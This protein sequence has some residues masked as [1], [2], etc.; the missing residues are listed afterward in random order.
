VVGTAQFD[1]S[2]V[3][4]R[5]WL[6]EDGTLYDLNQLLPAGSPW[7]ILAASAINGHGDIAAT[8]RFGTAPGTRAVLLRRQAGDGIFASTFAAP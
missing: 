4:G 2:P 8:A 7:L 1:A 3:G 6:L 5:G